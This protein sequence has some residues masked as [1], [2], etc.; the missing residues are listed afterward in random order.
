M[1]KIKNLISI[2]KLS[3]LTFLKIQSFAK[4][5]INR[6]KPPPHIL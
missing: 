5:D 1:I 6:E 2:K 4:N 3:S